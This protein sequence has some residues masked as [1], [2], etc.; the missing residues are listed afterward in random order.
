MRASFTPNSGPYGRHNFAAHLLSLNLLNH[1]ETCGA[2]AQRHT[3]TLTFDSIPA[4]EHFKAAGD[5][6]TSEG[7]RCMVNPQNNGQRLTVTGKIR[8]TVKR[9][10][11]PYHVDMANALF[12]L[13]KTE[14][15][16]IVGARYD[17]A[18]N[19][20]L[21]K[22]V[23]TGIRTVWLEVD[24]L[25]CIPQKIE[26]QQG[27]QKGTALV[28]VYGRPVACFKCW[29]EGH[30]RATC[31]APRCEKC[32]KFGHY[33]FDCKGKTYA[34]MAQGRA[35]VGTAPE[36]EIM[37]INFEDLHEAENADAHTA[38]KDPVTHVAEATSQA[39][40]QHVREETTNSETHSGGAAAAENNTQDAQRGEGE[41]AGKGQSGRQMTT[42][43]TSK[44]TAHSIESLTSTTRTSHT[45]GE[46]GRSP[47]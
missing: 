13:E 18:R 11:I 3:F 32:H 22:D 8:T 27:P 10:W 21:L 35:N 25:N 2:T 37:D 16:K 40:E 24:H 45:K 31:T 9:H 33:T 46:G 43:T 7:I 14:G 29:R 42:E 28:T 19:D 4:A 23:R 44:A 17:T 26:W 47:F 6:T 30:T 20:P 38:S 15:I 36:E 12:A 34:D 5:F 1:L 39:R 41:T